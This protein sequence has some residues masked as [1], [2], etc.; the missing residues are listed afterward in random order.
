[1]TA[2]GAAPMSALPI[3]DE[4]RREFVPAAP[5]APAKGTPAAA[6]SP[7]P[8]PSARSQGERDD[9]LAGYRACLARIKRNLDEGSTDAAILGELIE[10]LASAA[11]AKALADAGDHQPIYAVS[12]AF[13]DVLALTCDEAAAAQTLALRL[14]AVG[15]E[16][17]RQGGDTRG[18]KRLL[19]WRDQLVRGHMPPEMRD[20]YERAL[21]FARKAP[22]ALD[23]KGALDYATT[24][25]AR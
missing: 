7:G 6:P 19:L 2:D 23:V 15:Y 17:P 5:T 22:S 13:I 9:R 10:F 11:A 1:M 14:V 21:K 3:F 4:T 24:P 8:R 18:W 12:A 16:L 20:I 25:S